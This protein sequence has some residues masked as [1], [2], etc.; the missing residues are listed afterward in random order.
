MNASISVR[1]TNGVTLALHDLGGDGPP[2]LMC[3]ATGFHGRAY[4][5]FA[6][7]L[8]E[9]F[10][11]WAVD[12]RGHGDST[13]A[14]NGEFTWSGMGEDVLAATDAVVVPGQSIRAVG[15]SMG[16]A[17]I[18]LAELARPGTIEAA[19]LFEPI[20]M[21]SGWQRPIDNTH[22]SGPARKRRE[23]FPSRAEAMWR[24][25]ARPPLN[26]LRSDC[27]AAYV[28]YGFHDLEDGTVRLACRAESE[29]RTFE[30]AGLM[31]ADRASTIATPVTVGLGGADAGSNTATMAPGLVEALPN[32]RLVTYP[33]LGHFGPLEDPR[34]IAIDVRQT[35][36]PLG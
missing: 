11:V 21:P 31:T 34:T 28:E 10:H 19:Y 16:G 35:F 7:H 9:A 30:A 4:Q 12:F 32:G 3:H 33:H 1:S 20:V 15:H 25:A 2:L 36:G 8:A 26:A 18:L 13:I 17:A 5:S 27:L 6:R 22:M 14:E 24:Y 29:A 23:I